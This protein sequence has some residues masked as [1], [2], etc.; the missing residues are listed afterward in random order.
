ME[1]EQKIQRVKEILESLNNN[2]LNLKDGVNLYK[3]GVEMIN[4]AQKMLE[5]AKVQYEEIRDVSQENKNEGIK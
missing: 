5:E 3:E 1:F 2:E 4:Q